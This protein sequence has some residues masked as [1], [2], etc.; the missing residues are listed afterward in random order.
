[1]NLDGEKEN[2]RGGKSGPACLYLKESR[3][4][5]RERED[6]NVSR[7]TRRSLISPLP[8]APS[9]KS[10]PQFPVPLS[11]R[12]RIYY[13]SPFSSHFLFLVFSASGA[14]VGVVSGI[15]STDYQSAQ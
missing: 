7:F 6:T 10:P 14:S 12:T 8:R 5:E 4:K 9:I 13:T 1:M 3:R 11:L 2:G 15:N